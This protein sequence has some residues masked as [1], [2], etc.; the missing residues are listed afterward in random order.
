MSLRFRVMKTNRFVS[1][2][3]PD[4]IP[5]LSVEA[6]ALMRKRMARLKAHSLLVVLLQY[7]HFYDLHV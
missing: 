2:S 5:A 3:R 4:A 6:K 1:G 7:K